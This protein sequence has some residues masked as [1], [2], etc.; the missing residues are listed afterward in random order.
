[1]PKISR[2][3][4]LA[5]GGRALTVAAILPVAVTSAQAEV[6]ADDAEVFKAYEEWQRLEK[7]ASD[8][9]TEADVRHTAVQGLLPPKP[10]RWSISTV[11]EGTPEWDRLL[12]ARTLTEGVEELRKENEKALVA[13]RARCEPIYEREGVRELQRKADAAWRAAY[14]AETRFLKTPARTVAGLLVKLRYGC[15]P[16]NYGFEYPDTG[17]QPSGPPAVLA[18]LRDLER[19]AEGAV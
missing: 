10:P 15:E 12:T 5:R 3:T 2:R 13:W 6:E 18:T 9:D 4:A 7:V 16:W 8:A 19:L 17:D 14:A 11:K 1:M